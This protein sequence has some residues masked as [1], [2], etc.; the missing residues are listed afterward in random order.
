MAQIYG[1][2]SKYL[3]KKAEKY[4]YIALLLAIPMLFIFFIIVE[5]FNFFKNN[6]E[7]T[8]ILLGIFGLLY[9]IVNVV[10]E[11]LF[12]KSDNFI[13]GRKGESSVY[14]ELKR[15][16]DEYSVFQDIHFSG[17]AHNIDFVVLGP[18]GLFAVEVKSHKGGEV[19]FNGQE[20]TWNGAPFQEKDFLKQAKSEALALNKYLKEKIQKDIFVQPVIVFANFVKL[21]FGK[22]PVGGVYVIQ[23]EWLNNLITENPQKLSVDNLIKIS[24]ALGTLVD[25]S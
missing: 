20:L 23:K 5:H 25:R 22:K 6:T 16:S 15:L 19:N 11:K 2:Q 17:Q 21:H 4:R 10:S 24:E 1:K 18:T 7:A 12:K 3:R 13:D 9:I 14:F 8:I